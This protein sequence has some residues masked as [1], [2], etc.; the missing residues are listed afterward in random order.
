V[1]RYL[2]KRVKGYCPVLSTRYCLEHKKNP[3][4][5]APSYH[6]YDSGALQS[7]SVSFSLKM[8]RH[9]VMILRYGHNHFLFKAPVHIFLGIGLQFPTLRPIE[10]IVADN[11]HIENISFNGQEAFV[12]F[13]EPGTL[14]R[15]EKCCPCYMLYFP[16]L[17]HGTNSASLQTIVSRNRIRP[18]DGVE[19]STG[20]SGP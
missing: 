19:G 14:S 6:K 12:R 18:P 3:F 9:S 20:G 7:P 10:S 2:S 4:L 5:P 13:R 17:E 11:L 1:C 16:H 15:P 8:T